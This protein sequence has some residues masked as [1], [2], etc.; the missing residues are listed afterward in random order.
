M[1]SRQS[2]RFEKLRLG[3]QQFK[4]NTSTTT[5]VAQGI[6]TRKN[7]PS[8]EELVD[9]LGRGILEIVID[10]RNFGASWCVVVHHVD[11]SAL[12]RSLG[13][14]GWLREVDQGG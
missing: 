3:P 13:V 5:F 11:S 6:E 7:L 9:F 8:L 10:E 1:S 2:A 14:E 12:S 4:F